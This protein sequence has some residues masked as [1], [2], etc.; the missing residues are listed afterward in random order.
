M[1]ARWG[2]SN[3]VLTAQ[4]SSTRRIP[5]TRAGTNYSQRRKRGIA[6]GSAY[7]APPCQAHIIPTH[8]SLSLHHAW[9]V[10]LP[11][12]AGMNVWR[13]KHLQCFCTTSRH[14]AGAS[15]P[16]HRRL[17]D[18]RRFMFDYFGG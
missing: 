15:Q 4:I 16:E 10:G 18:I 13:A 2:A 6:R 1:V 5:A 17:S 12:A 9:A 14:C 3:C 8:G 7:T 11:S